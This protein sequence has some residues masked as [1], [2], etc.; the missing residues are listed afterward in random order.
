[1]ALLKNQDRRYLM[2]MFIQ[3]KCFGLSCCVAEY[4]FTNNAVLYLR[5]HECLEHCCENFRSYAYVYF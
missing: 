1:M 3:I 4:I 5:R 2:T